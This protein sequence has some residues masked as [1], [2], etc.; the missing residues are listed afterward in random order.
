MFVTNRR[1]FV[2]YCVSCCGC[3]FLTDF[4][5]S[6]S[7]VSSHSRK[8]RLTTFITLKL[9]W[10]A[11]LSPKTTIP[12]STN[13]SF[14]IFTLS[15]LHLSG[16]MRNRFTICLFLLITP[17]LIWSGEINTER[18]TVFQR[19]WPWK[20]PHRKKPDHK[21]AVN[22]VLG[23]RSSERK[24]N[25]FTV[26]QAENRSGGGVPHT[27]PHT[28]TNTFFGFGEQPHVILNMRMSPLII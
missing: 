24:R 17:F 26:D 4:F 1:Y 11:K 25:N 12:A 13:V 16:A 6:C 14:P 15:F 27:K 9:C 10:S 8:F 21:T 18:F 3:N 20:S 19:N 28:H 7:K 2:C 5:N 22:I 23:T